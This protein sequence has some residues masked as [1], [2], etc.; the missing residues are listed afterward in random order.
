MQKLSL[1]VYLR[2]DNS[3]T[4]R[5]K[6]SWLQENNKMPSL[7]GRDDA[8]LISDNELLVDQTSAHGIFAQLCGDLASASHPYLLLPL[9]AESSVAVGKFPD[10]TKAILEKYGVPFSIS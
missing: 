10:T 2:N 8:V 7:E 4:L 1:L 9:D 6:I 5:S 3:N